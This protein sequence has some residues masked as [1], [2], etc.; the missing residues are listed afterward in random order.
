MTFSISRQIASFG[1]AIV[2][3]GHAGKAG[4]AEDAYPTFKEGGG[5]WTYQQV[6]QAG[7]RREVFTPK[8][9]VG[10]RNG[11]SVTFLIQDS[12]VVP[13]VA[14]PA[15][16]V[17]GDACGVDIAGGAVVLAGHPCNVPLVAGDSWD[18]KAESRGMTTSFSN[19]YAGQEDVTVPAG[20]F[21]AYKIQS[22]Q[23]FTYDDV[24]KA[25]KSSLT[26]YWYVPKIRGMVRVERH[27]FDEQNRATLVMTEEMTA[28]TER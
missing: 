18:S 27:L 17:N 16:A 5:T 13:S 28:H 15:F 11:N 2:V 7:I 14:Q 1:V 19:T 23:V 10:Y 12:K 22:R 9:S 24:G 8:F 3:A 4:A 26:T 20:V 6:T 21:S 25:S